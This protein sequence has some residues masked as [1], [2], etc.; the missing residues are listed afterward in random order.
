MWVLDNTVT[1]CLRGIE[2]KGADLTLTGNV[3]TNAS[4]AGIVVDRHVI[5]TERVALDDNTIT[6]GPASG[7]IGLLLLNVTSGPD[8]N[9]GT[10]AFQGDLDWFIRLANSAG[11]SRTSVNVNAKQADFGGATL[12]QIEAKIHDQIDDALLGLVLLNQAPTAV[13]LVNGAESVT[14]EQATHAG[15]EVTLDGSGSSDPDGDALTYAWD[16]E[17]D[18]TVD[19][20]E[21]VVSHTYNLGGP[22]TATL[23]VTDPASASSSDTVTVTVEDT[24]PPTVAI[25][26]PADGSTQY[27]TDGP[28]LVTVTV[29]DACDSA[30]ALALT[31]DGEPFSGTEI[32]VA[33]L[34]LGEHTLAATATDASGNE[35]SGSSTFTV[36]ARPLGSFCVRELKIEWRDG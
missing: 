7:D 30:P 3:V 12:A 17:T 31:L 14:V 28:V 27:N 35:G 18:G 8:I 23:T 10:T 32:D 11:A 26:S 29:T 6:G 2:V 25:D 5:A 1:N 15:T 24:T 19:S 16:F 36:A 22:Y 20:T 4:E 13:A 9:L 21:A 33:D 34:D